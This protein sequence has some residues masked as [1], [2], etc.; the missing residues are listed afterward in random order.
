MDSSGF[1]RGEIVADSCLRKIQEMWKQGNTHHL[2]TV[3][4]MMRWVFECLF[5]TKRFGHVSWESIIEQQ[6]RKPFVKVQKSGLFCS[7]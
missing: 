6:S 5:L 4:L 7:E 2:V 1:L 3:M